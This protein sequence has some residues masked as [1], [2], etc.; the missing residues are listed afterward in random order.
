MAS[1]FKKTRKEGFGDEVKRRIMLGTY[2][3]SAGYYDAYYL[4][5]LKVRHLIQD[6]FK[7]AFE[8]YDCLLTPASVVTAPKIGVEYDA[9]TTYKQDICTVTSNLAGLPAISVP[10]GKDE[11]DM[12]IGIQFIGKPFDE[13]FLLQVA[14]AVEQSAKEAE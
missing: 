10:Y 11:N 7:R 12:P 6:D 2:A 1:M 14:Y 5:A 8:K 4:K 9:V 3:L 13:A